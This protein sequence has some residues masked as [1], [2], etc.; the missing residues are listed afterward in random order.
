MKI[1]RLSLGIDIGTSKIC[2][3][4]FETHT[5]RIKC[6]M[7]NDSVTIPTKIIIPHANPEKLIFFPELLDQKIQDDDTVID[8]TKR[9]VICEWTYQ[10]KRGKI[11]QGDCVNPRNY[12]NKDWC[13]EGQ[14]HFTLGRLEWRPQALFIQLLNNAIKL[15]ETAL[16]EEYSET[17][18]EISEIKVGV[19]MIFH[20]AEIYVNLLESIVKDICNTSLGHKLSA[21]K[22]INVIQEPIATLMAHSYGKPDILPQ[23][24]FLVVDSGAGTTDIV[25]CEKSGDKISFIDYESWNLAGDDYDI[26]MEATIEEILKERKIDVPKKLQVAAVKEAKE[27]YCNTKSEPSLSIPKIKPVNIPIDKIEKHFSR[28]NDLIARELKNFIDKHRLRDIE[29]RKLYLSGGCINVESLTKAIQKAVAITQDDTSNIKINDPDLRRY[30][31]MIIGVSVGS[32][33]PEKRYA[34]IMSYTLPVDIV[35]EEVSYSLNIQDRFTKVETLYKANQGSASRE[36][37]LKGL[38]PNTTLVLRAINPK[39]D[40]RELQRIKVNRYYKEHKRGRSRPL[41]LKIKCCVGYNA[42]LDIHV[43]SNH[44]PSEKLVYGDFVQF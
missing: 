13:R 14:R 29:I 30:D 21:D 34:K 4:M 32:A 40:Q 42:K 10:M 19:P 22:V 33:I 5:K 37:S 36:V 27:F 8:S 2:V 3:T 35:I 39:G 31:P 24:Y 7:F 6:L 23:G 43:L 25:L 44:V 16:E 1:R 15:T 20:R 41:V 12:K 18:Y 11:E 26:A 17:D 28:V 38:K 9:C